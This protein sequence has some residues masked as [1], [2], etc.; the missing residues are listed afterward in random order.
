MTKHLLPLIPGGLAVEQVLPEPHRGAERPEGEPC[1]HQHNAGDQQR[2][3]VHAPAGSG[4][5]C[6]IHH[7]AEDAGRN[8]LVASLV[9]SPP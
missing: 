9:V 3:L 6:S 1:L 2:Q 4:A 8:P 7:V 5:G